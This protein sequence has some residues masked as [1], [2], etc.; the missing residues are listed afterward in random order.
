MVILLCYYTQRSFSFWRRRARRLYVTF[1]GPRAQIDRQLY[2]QAMQKELS[3]TEN[4]TILG[5]PVEDLILNEPTGL[6]SSNARVKFR[7]GGIVL[8]KDTC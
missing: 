8:G 4:L 1:Q 2:K 3:A 7:C 6:S 5:A